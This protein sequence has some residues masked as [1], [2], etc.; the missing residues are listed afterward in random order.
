MAEI[1]SAEDEFVRREL[2]RH[3]E[4]LSKLFRDSIKKQRLI[5]SKRLVEDFEG[6][7]WRVNA[8]EKTLVFDFP[9]YG[10]AIEINYHKLGKLRRLRSIT[11][12]AKRAAW[13]IDSRP[14]QKPRKNTRWYAHNLYGSLNTLIGRISWGYTEEV[15]AEIKA[16]LLQSLPDKNRIVL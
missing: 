5:K 11:Q 14:K 2:T 10:R 4:Y 13:G 15:A 6:I 16:A 8:A 9:G 7:S 1:L 12:E 3:G